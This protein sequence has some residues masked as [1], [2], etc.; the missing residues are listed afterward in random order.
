M[1]IEAAIKTA[2]DYEVKVRDA[3]LQAAKATD[4]AT[5]KKIFK[6]LGQEEQH[7]VNYLRER[8]DEWQK[9][10]HIAAAKLDSVVPSPK[11]I[12]EGVAV[13]DKHLKR[14]V[15]DSQRE[16]LEKAL[17]LEKETSAFYEKMVAQMGADGKLFERFMEIEKGHVAIVQA[18][19]DYLNHSGYFF[20]FQD[21]AMV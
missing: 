15:N 11:Q 5:A 18:E 17:A 1:T 14:E 21:F 9:S 3:Y 20:D 2:L 7:H 19:I 13:L 6:T 8:L 12:A 10:G 4:D 16:S